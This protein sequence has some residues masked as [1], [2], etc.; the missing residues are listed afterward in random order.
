MIWTQLF[1]ASGVDKGGI[2]HAIISDKV[3]GLDTQP[4]KIRILCQCSFFNFG[5][6]FERLSKLT[7]IAMT[8]GNA[9]PSSY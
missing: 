3:N 4:F 9:I 5:R 2:L 6:H 7:S 8:V 1:D